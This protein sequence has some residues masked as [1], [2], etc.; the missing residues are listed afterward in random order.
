VVLNQRY[1]EKVGVSRTSAAAGISL[2]LFAGAVVR[3][4]I[5]VSIG[6][7]VGT[8][9][10]VFHFDLTGSP[11]L[12]LIPI[13]AVIIGVIVWRAVGS[14]AARAKASA[15]AASKEFASVFRQPRRAAALL[16]VSAGLPISYGLVLIASAA[17]FSVDVAL[18]DMFAVYLAGTAVAAA[19]PTPGNL[20]AVE[21]TLSTGLVAIGVP[22]GA[23]VAAVL[24]YRLLTFWLPLLPGFMA[25][26]YLQAKHYI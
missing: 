24:M 9:A 25:F 1:L 21:V 4:V 26:R 13:A 22:S 12:L 6:S 19:S 18:I 23:A 2:R 8:G 5:M 3:V 16:G 11:Y 15:A 14:R 7:V 17:A 20:G 10:E